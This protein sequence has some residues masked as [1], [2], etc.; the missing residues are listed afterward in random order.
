MLFTAAARH[1][2]RQVTLPIVLVSITMMHYYQLCLFSCYC[3]CYCYLSGAPHSS[4]HASRQV[5]FDSDAGRPGHRRPDQANPIRL[6][7]TQAVII[8]DTIVLNANIVNHNPIIIN[9]IIINHILLLLLII[10]I[11][12][13]IIHMIILIKVLMLGRRARPSRPRSG[14]SASSTSRRS[15]AH[16]LAYARRAS[17]SLYSK[18]L[19]YITCCNLIQC[20]NDTH[21]CMCTDIYVRHAS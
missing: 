18:G 3:H 7:L 15:L 4:R 16:K 9:T 8:G 10:I 11:L 20:D 21:A 5:R 13:I 2:S 19:H 1:A 17:L 12:I 14:T 6:C